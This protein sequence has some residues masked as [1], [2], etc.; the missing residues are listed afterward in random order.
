MESTI[1][2]GIT[3]GLL[4][5]VGLI[6]IYITINSQQNIQKAKEYIWELTFLAKEFGG[7][8][9]RESAKRIEWILNHY[10]DLQKSSRPIKLV[11]A[12]SVVVIIF[13]GTTWL[14][15]VSLN[16]ISFNNFLFYVTL[17]SLIILFFFI[18]ILISLTNPS[19]IG[20]LPTTSEL[21][22]IK[23]N[24]LGLNMT[25]IMFEHAS[26]TFLYGYRDYEL[27]CKISFPTSIN[28]N[29]VVYVLSVVGPDY[30][31][32]TQDHFYIDLDEY[33]TKSNE[34]NFDFGTATLKDITK[35]NSI[36]TIGF[37]LF[38]LDSQLNEKGEAVV[39]ARNS[40]TLKDIALYTNSLGGATT[41]F[42]SY[43]TF[44]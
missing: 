8:R 31:E 30:N 32:F 35:T 25:K 33:D 22:N 39:L 13:C 41:T 34:I 28:S 27:N 44:L 7:D 16:I 4:T 21:L 23:Y 38:L 37:D 9:D 40:Y 42:P 26:L 1:I 10:S 15:F 19:F 43:T 20:N 12:L 14:L 18:L 29:D 17:G 36:S 2:F 6:A 3:S 24:K 11:V 5:L